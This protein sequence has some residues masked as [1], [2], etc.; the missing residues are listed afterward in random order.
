MSKAR[1]KRDDTVVV[2]AGKDK[3][4]VG[5]VLRV[6]PEDQNLVVEGVRRVKRHTKPVGDNPGTITEKENPIAVSNVALWNAA[7]KRRIKVGF[8]VLDDGKKIR[9]DKKTGLAID[10]A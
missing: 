1:I 2:I 6:N 4:K 9:V 3:G 5:R 8:K 10:N 7:E